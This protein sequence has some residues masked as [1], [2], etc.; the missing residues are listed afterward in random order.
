M[1]CHTCVGNSVGLLLPVGLSHMVG[2]DLE[3]LFTLRVAIGQAN[4]QLRHVQQVWALIQQHAGLLL[5]A[6]QSG[7]QMAHVAQGSY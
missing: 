6:G 1:G 7:T 4:T 5:A 3:G 2:T